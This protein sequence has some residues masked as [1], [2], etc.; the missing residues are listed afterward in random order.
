M[1]KIIE[2]SI[3]CKA[4]LEE[5]KRKCDILFVDKKKRNRDFAY[6]ISLAKKQNV[7]VQYCTRDQIEQIVQGKTHGGIALQA[8][9]LQ[10]KY[11][12]EKI[13]GFLCYINGIEDPY[14]LGSLIRSLYAS[15]CSSLILP[16]RDWSTSENIILRASAGAYER[17][18]I[19]FVRSDEELVMYLKDNQI[20]LYSAYRKDACAYYDIT[21]PDDF[22]I[23]IGGA[24]RGLSATIIK[25]SLQNIV[26]E[27]GRD[28]R[29]ALDTPS[30]TAVLAFEVMQQKKKRG[31][32]NDSV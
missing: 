4:V 1:K 30:A 10:I 2:G 16:Y 13:N 29:N 21:Y 12:N 15:G 6:I 8:E 9:S 5:K 18:P 24:L 25:A 22:C 3:S 28:F 14:N 23:A 7:E 32:Y 11:L 26:I 17:L 19:Y 20:P 27:Y 31:G